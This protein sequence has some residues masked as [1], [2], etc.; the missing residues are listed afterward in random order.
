MTDRNDMT[1]YHPED[2]KGGDDA[3]QQA[4]QMLEQLGY[5]VP[6]RQ[7][8]F[9]DA[10]VRDEIEG[11]DER[12]VSSERSWDGG[13]F[14]VDTVTVELPDGELRQRSIVRHPGAVGIIALDDNGRILLVNQYRTALERVTLEIP[15][16]KLEPGETA[17]EC[18]RRELEEETGYVP[19]ELRYFIPMASAIGYSDEIIHLFLATALK[20]GDS[21]PDDDE[22]IAV[23]WMDATELIDLVLDGRIEDAKTIVAALACDSIAHRLV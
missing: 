11:I 7:E 20:P 17:E 18:A 2:D 6:R 4:M 9:Q 21:H 8:D 1:L 14:D 12:I 22:F 16:G 10:F 19:G 5:R 15:A 13:F 23:Q 3:E